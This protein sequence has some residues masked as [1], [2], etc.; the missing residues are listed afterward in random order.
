MALLKQSPAVLDISFES[1]DD[2]I[3]TLIFTDFDI[4]GCTFEATIDIGTENITVPVTPEVE[5]HTLKIVFPK[6]IASGVFTWK[7]K[8]VQK[9][10][11]R[12]FING[13]VTVK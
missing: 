1:G 9:L 2:F 11:E 5:T 7:L 3:I 8:V 10:I 12:T 6:D 4:A 13:T